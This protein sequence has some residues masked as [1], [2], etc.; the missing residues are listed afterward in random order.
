MAARVNFVAAESA[1]KG[2]APVRIDQVALEIAGKTTAP[3]RLSAAFTEAAAKGIAPL[4]LAFVALETLVQ[5]E[6]PPTVSTEKL[7]L[8]PGLTW[9]VHISPKFNTRVA[10]HVSGREIRT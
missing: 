1:A 3:I 9:S 6:S 5:I 10:G 4:R 2:T 7:P 8:A